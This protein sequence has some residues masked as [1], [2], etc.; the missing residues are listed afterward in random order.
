MSKRI[1]IGGLA[2]ASIA[3]LV[4]AFLGTDTARTVILDNLDLTANTL[5]FLDGTASAATVT[6]L[7][8]TEYGVLES[9]LNYNGVSEARKSVAKAATSAT[10]IWA[11]NKMGCSHNEVGAYL[12]DMAYDLDLLTMYGSTILAQLGAWGSTIYHSVKTFCH[13]DKEEPEDGKKQSE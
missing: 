9:I 7:I 13:L 10:C 8:A 3:S 6:G 5:K 12:R 11:A 2:V 1:I 4:D